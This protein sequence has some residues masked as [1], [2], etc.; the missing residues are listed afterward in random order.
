[1]KEELYI[2]IQN[3][4]EIIRESSNDYI[5][6]GDVI[7]TYSHSRAVKDFITAA[8]EKRTTSSMGIDVI[9]CETFPTLSGQQFAMELAAAG[10]R[11]SLIHDAASFSVMSQCTKVVIG[12]HAVLANGGV[13]VPS[14]GSNIVMAANQFKVPVI[15]LTG[16]YKVSCYYIHDFKIK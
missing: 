12:C 2:D 14:G 4:S 6:S 9:C 3:A 15:V 11:T 5:N 8:N 10:I 13:L 1:M 7:L 16:I